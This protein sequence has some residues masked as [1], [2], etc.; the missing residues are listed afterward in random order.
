MVSDQSMGG[1]NSIQRWPAFGPRS[2]LSTL[3][4]K[5]NLI[6]G[7]YKKENSWKLFFKELQ[8]Y[9]GIAW[10]EKERT[11]KCEQ[12]A[13]KGGN[14]SVYVVQS[15][16]A[17]Y[18]AWNSRLSRKISDRYVSPDGSE[19]VVQRHASYFAFHIKKYVRTGGYVIHIPR[20]LKLS[21]PS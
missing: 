3:I 8:I 20:S 21:C 16:Q 19:R 9:V 17:H 5:K 13:R 6:Y 14:W 18:A 15:D 2:S 12:A 1:I 11:W 10:K 4:T 7:R